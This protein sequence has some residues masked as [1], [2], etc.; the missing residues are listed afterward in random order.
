MRIPVIRGIMDRRILVNYR[1]DQDVLARLLP[2]PFRP[3]LVS[4]FGVASVCVI[5][6]QD[7]STLLMRNID[8][9][10][11][12]REPLLTKANHVLIA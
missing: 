12:G 4:G 1:V 11:H 3:K 10:W 5:R 8:H 9:E 7:I 2:A 6:L